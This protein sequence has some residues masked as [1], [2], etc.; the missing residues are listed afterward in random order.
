MGIY[1]ANTQQFAGGVSSKFWDL[2]RTNVEKF[3]FFS[4]NLVDM[5]YIIYYIYI[6]G[7]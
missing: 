4:I 3:D 2:I 1:P 6:M 7:I 5:M